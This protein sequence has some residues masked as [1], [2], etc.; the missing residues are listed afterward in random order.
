MKFKKGYIPWN[1]GKSYKLGSGLRK[2][3][4]YCGIEFKARKSSVYCSRSCRNKANPIRYTEDMKAKHREACSGNNAGESNPSYGKKGVD[5][6]TYGT[7][8]T[9]EVKQRL[10]ELKKGKYRLENNPN[11]KGGKSFEVYPPEFS[12][13]LKTGIRRRDGFTCQFCGKN[14]FDVHHIDYDKNNNTENNLITLCKKCHP[15]TNHNRDYWQGLL[16]K[17]MEVAA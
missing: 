15:K 8:R 6:W 17:K 11:W 4:P 13:E 5:S 10:S 2:T 7:K 14:G 9:E 3:C 1:K 16:S 12:R